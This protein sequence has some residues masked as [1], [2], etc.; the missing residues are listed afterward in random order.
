MSYENVPR[1]IREIPEHLKTQEISNGAVLI[2][3]Y[4]LEVLPD[5]L[6]TQEMCNELVHR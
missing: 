6:K 3:P 1:W 2:E 4:S 5:H